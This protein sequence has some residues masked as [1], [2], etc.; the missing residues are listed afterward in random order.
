VRIHIIGI[1]YWP[2]ATGIAVFSTGRAEHLAAAGHDVT[3]CAAVPYYPWWR[4]LDG[5]RGWRVRKERRA[6]VTILRCPIYVPAA[7]RPLTRVLHE[8][9]FIV[10]AFLRSLFSRRP[11]VLFV[12][13]PPLGLAAT[14]ALLARL[15]RV[16]FVFHVA[17][18]QPD[19]ALDLGMVRPGRLARLLYA[20]ESLAYRRAAIVSTL[21]EA[22]RARIVAKGVPSNKV[23]L[24]ADWAD[25]RLFALTADAGGDA[26][27]RELGVDGAF[28]VLHAGNMGVKQ[29]L[30]VVLDAAN[31]TRSDSGLVYL[32]VGD[33]AVRPQLEARVR[34]LGLAN[35][36][37]VP[38]LPE[39]RFLALLATADVCLI[40]QQRS[41]ADVVFP[42]K[43]LTL[44]AAG[45]P[46]IAAV[47]DGSAVAD[48][49]AASGAGAVIVPEDGERLAQAVATLRGDPERRAVLSAAGRAYAR[50]HWERSRTLSYL[51]DTIDRLAGSAQR[52]PIASAGEWRPPA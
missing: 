7:V 52:H 16:P 40:T 4:V 6:G 32:L 19:T 31:R 38:L 51:T 50:L 15:W 21:T 13:S 36:K 1:N 12:V 45:K 46:V 5:Y 26:I 8:A 33:G 42:S 9:S 25:P 47:T 27:R 3:M 49:I 11:D 29:G 48:A 44:L 34:S 10:T 18:L 22:M 28:L 24:F 20:V 37:I 35:V 17:D 14:A 2:E 23:V 39:E 43:V 41:V 30:D